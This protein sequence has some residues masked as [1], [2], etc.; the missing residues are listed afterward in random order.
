MLIRSPSGM[1]YELLGGFQHQRNK[2][3]SLRENFG[4]SKD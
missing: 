4:R 3:S 1:I 2:L